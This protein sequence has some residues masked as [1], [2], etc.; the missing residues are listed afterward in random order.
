MSEENKEATVLP[1]F[2]QVL[3]Q[4]AEGNDFAEGGP[5]EPIAE[6]ERVIGE[7]SPWQKA[8]YARMKS[9]RNQAGEMSTEMES[10]G[11]QSLL[12]EAKAIESILDISIREGMENNG[13]AII[14]MRQGWTLVDADTCGCPACQARR[15]GISFPGNAVG[16]MVVGIGTGERPN[17]I[18]GLL[19]KILVI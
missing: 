19:A 2:I 10:E 17:G 16:M 3:V 18:E 7:M 13:P 5:D 15:A 8:C 6:S 4:M 9:L 14:G 12:H 11:I 1:G